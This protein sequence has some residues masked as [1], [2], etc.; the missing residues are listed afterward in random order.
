MDQ[1]VDELRVTLERDPWGE[2]NVAVYG[3]QQDGQ[4]F[5]CSDREVGPDTTALELAAWLAKAL[6]RRMGLRLR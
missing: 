5:L 6:T 4:M 3:V 2:W 1:I